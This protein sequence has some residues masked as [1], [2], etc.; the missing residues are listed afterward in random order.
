MAPLTPA[1]VHVLLSLAG[2]ERHGYAILKDVFKTEVYE[3]AAYRNSISDAIPGNVLTKPP[4]AELRPDQKDS[5]SLPAYDELDPI[6]EG[7]IER[8]QGVS[9]LV[10]AGHDEATVTKVIALVDRAEYKRRQAPPGAK[11]T[12][13][14]FGRDRRLPITS[15]WREGEVGP[16]P[17]KVV[18]E[19]GTE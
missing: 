2:G 3:L 17:A 16:L 19:A 13:K 15:R 14:A 7:Y 12:T 6:L 18:G 9:D 8:D 4:S 5:D 11:V 1:V 10:A